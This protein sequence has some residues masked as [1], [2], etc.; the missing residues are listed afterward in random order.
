MR[1][2]TLAVDLLYCSNGGAFIQRL[3]GNVTKARQEP[4]QLVQQLLPGR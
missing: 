2:K 1:A 3:P 4:G